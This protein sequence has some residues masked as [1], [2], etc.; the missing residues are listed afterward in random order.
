MKYFLIFFVL[1][2]F[3]IHQAFGTEELIHGYSKFELLPSEV[4]PDNPTSFEIVF[5]Y[6]DHPYS[7]E[8]LSPVIEINPSSARSNV[9]IN[10]APIN[11]YPGQIFR[12]PVTMT[13]DSKIKHEKFFLTL[14]FIGNDSKTDTVY[15]SDWTE[16]AIMDVIQN[17][18]GSDDLPSSQE[19][20][21]EKL[22]GATCDGK[23]TLC[24]GTFLNGTTIPVQCDYVI[25]GC[26]A[27]PSDYVVSILSPLKQ[28]KTEIPFDDI[29]CKENLVLVKKYNGFP[30]CVKP[31]TDPKLMQ[32]GWILPE[33]NPEPT[34]GPEPSPEPAP[35]SESETLQKQKQQ[36]A[37]LHTQ[38]VIMT[39]YRDP[40]YH[41]RA[42]NDYRNEF[43]SG[44]FLEQ[45]IFS[46]KQN[47]EKDD[48]I[49]F[50]VVEW[51]YQP[52]K[53]TYPKVEVYLRPYDNYDKIE[54]ISEWQKPDDACFSISSDSD[55][56]LIMNL[57]PMPIFEPYQT[58]TIPGEYRVVASNLEDESKKEFGYYTCQKEKLVGLPQ[59]WME[60]PE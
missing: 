30:A 47:Y 19:Y 45:F 5:M 21:F 7:I 23:A 58:C 28:F 55:G 59:P 18:V 8:S 14:S 24:Y 51:G 56:Y 36:Q 52:Q 1:I 49:N 46:N 32:R 43:E 2:G 53:C 12:I 54:K 9:H 25:H 16:S 26:G 44:Y 38:E 11:V 37:K 57:W 4:T 3:T 27:I 60:L 35:M 22:T 34:P 13:V 10:V 40:Q 41:I 17:N 50:I 48:L 39:D 29:E 42:I 33:L 6:Y 15:K 31:E 20:Q